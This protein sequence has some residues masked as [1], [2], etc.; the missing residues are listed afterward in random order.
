MN[1]LLKLI[2]VLLSAFALMG[3]IAMIPLDKYQE[4]Y[5]DELH[6]IKTEPQRRMEATLRYIE[7]IENGEEDISNGILSTPP[8]KYYPAPIPRI[9]KAENNTTETTS[10]NQ[11]KYEKPLYIRDKNNPNI[12]HKY[13]E[14]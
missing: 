8:K 5:L 4:V 13:T 7:A 3:V 6:R 14:N 9:K 1:E 2:W 11:N 10:H 12:L